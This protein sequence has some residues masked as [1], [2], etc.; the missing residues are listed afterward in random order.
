MSAD[1]HIADYPVSFGVS[2]NQLSI[3]GDMAQSIYNSEPCTFTPAVTTN[4]V[5]W[6]PSTWPTYT[7]NDKFGIAFKVA[8]KLMEKKIVKIDNNIEKFL[9]LVNSI[10]E[11]L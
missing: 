10:A 2:N 4:C 9:K 5:S 6:W 7:N 11:E 8:Q 3:I 1:M